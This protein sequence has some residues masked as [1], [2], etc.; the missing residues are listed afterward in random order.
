[1][2]LPT[3]DGKELDLVFPRSTVGLASA[4]V[5]R[6]VAMAPLLALLSRRHDI[7]LGGGFTTLADT[8]APPPQ[9]DLPTL[10]ANAKR[11]KRQKKHMKWHKTFAGWLAGEYR[12]E[13]RMLR[14]RLCDRRSCLSDARG[15]V[16]TEAR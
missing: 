6:M 5:L 11:E 15:S 13:W 1:M 7:V 3:E 10:E 16:T 8:T 2:L 4:A 9:F 14:S 12:G